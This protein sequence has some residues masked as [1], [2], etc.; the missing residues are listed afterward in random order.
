MLHE[1]VG[2][3][4]KIAGVGVVIGIAAAAAAARLLEAFL[5]GLRP[6]DVPT[7]TTVAILFIMVILV[8]AYAAARK[9]LNVDPVVA[10]RHE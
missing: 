2:G 1:V 5:Y 3:A 6:F 9:A 4:L 8:A 7:F 10:L